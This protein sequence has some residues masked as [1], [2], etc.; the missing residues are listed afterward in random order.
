MASLGRLCLI[1]VLALATSGALCTNSLATDEDGTVT[2]PRIA[3]PSRT[4][5]G[6]WRTKVQQVFDERTRELVRRTYTIWD[7]EPSRD[8]DFVWTPDEPAAEKSGRINGNGHLVWRIKGKP[9]YERSSVF[10]EYHGTLG[11]GRMEGPGAWLDETGLLY[12]GQWKN[13]LMHGQG[14][15][16]LPSGDEYTGS[17]RAGKANGVGRYIDITGEV[18]DGPFVDGQRHGKGT[19]TLPS[20]Q[21]YTSLWSYGREAE[22]SH[23]VRLA[24]IGARV[25]PGGA[26]DVRIGITVDKRLPQAPR[27]DPRPEKGDL[28]YSV[29]NS[30]DGVAIRPDDARLMRMWKGGGEIQISAAE[31]VGDGDVYGPLALSEG[32]MVPLKLVL[33]VQNR[34]SVALNVNGAYLD[35]SSSIADLQPAIQ[36]STRMHEC[37]EPFYRPTFK[38]ENFGWGPAEQAIVSFDFANSAGG[39]RP[40]SFG[41]SKTLGQIDKTLNVNI[42]SDLRSAGIN[43]SILSRNKGAIDC[44]KPKTTQ[45]CLQDLKASGALGSLSDKVRL[46]DNFVVTNAV[47]KLNYIWRDARGATKQVS[48]PFNANIPLGFLRQDVECGEGGERQQI[49]AS[50]QQLRLDAS[51][52]R[53]PISFRSTIAAGNTG[54]LTLPLKAQKS[55]EH[56]FIV[57]LQLADGREIKS[58]RI[59]LLYYRPSWIHVSN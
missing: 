40:A 17:F 59:N 4:E 41:R 49:T 7:P 18:Y 32:R 31:E 28:W 51:N 46:I 5:Q 19:T 43:T 26:D 33:D 9:A 44:K 16:K 55:S 2:D 14:M 39:G 3:G 30:A 27:S 21:Q 37:Y 20:G 25:A 22:A 34:S 1:S 48:S 23:R 8:L 35:V 58:R 50:S 54:R 12:D 24:Q 29:S 52:Y 47:G 38:L 45:A 11:R 42:E 15:L 13:G 56:D 36:L 6:Q 57:T 53:I 10:A